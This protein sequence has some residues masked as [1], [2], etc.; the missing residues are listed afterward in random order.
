M[1]CSRLIFFIECNIILIIN[2]FYY[3]MIEN[4]IK[5]IMFSLFIDVVCYMYL[6]NSVGYLS[7]VFLDV[8]VVFCF[9]IVRLDNGVIFWEG[10]I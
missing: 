8:I 9:V 10:M 2:Y 4:K 6:I 3:V 1:N 7:I 5:N